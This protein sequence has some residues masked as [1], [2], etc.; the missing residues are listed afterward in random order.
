ML[1]LKFLGRILFQLA[2]NEFTI[3]LYVIGMIGLFLWTLITYP[4][5]A[6]ISLAIISVV[7]FIGYI[8]SEW[9]DFMRE[10]VSKDV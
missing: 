2:F 4:W 9:H 1:Y 10:Q 7:I 3:F 6:G 8:V 5:V